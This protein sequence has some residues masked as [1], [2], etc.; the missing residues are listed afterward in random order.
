MLIDSDRKYNATNFINVKKG[1]QAID[2]DHYTQVLRVKL[3]KCPNPKARQEIYNFKNSQYQQIFREITEHTD[4]FQKKIKGNFPPA[5]K[6]FRWKNVLNTYCMRAFRKM[7]V[8]T[9]RCK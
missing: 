8:K 1:G 5:T 6:F 3:E 2:T 7:C 4:D 9:K